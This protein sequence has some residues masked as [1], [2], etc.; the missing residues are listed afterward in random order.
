MKRVAGQALAE[1]VGVLAVLVA[2]LV[3]PVLGGES[4]VVRLG[5]ALRLYWRAW[6]SALLSVAGSP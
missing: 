5:A 2:A 4:V 3:L 6:S 1:Y